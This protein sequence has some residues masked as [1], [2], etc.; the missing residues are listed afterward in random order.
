MALPRPVGRQSDV[1]Y[2]PSSGHQVILGTAGTGKTVMAM[3]RALHLASPD[4][5]GAG[6]VLLVTY[7]NALVTYLS[8]LRGG[9]AGGVTVETYGKFARGYLHSLGLMPGWGGI[10]GP[11]LRRTLVRKAVN[12]VSSGYKPSPFFERD[13]AFFLDELE[14]LSANGVTTLEE[15]KGLD[16]YGRKVG[17]S[18]A[19]RAAVWEIHEK[20]VGLRD[21]QGPRYDWYDLATSV[22]TA[23]GRDVRPRRYQHVVIDEGQDLSPE[24]IRSLVSAA[25]QSGSVTFF[26][27]YAQQIYGQDVSWRACGLNVR[28]VERFQDNYRNTA[29]IARLA[30][31]MSQ[32]PTFGGNPDDLVEPRAPRAAGTLPALVRCD[33]CDDEINIV[34]R[35][36]EELGR[37]GTVAVLGRTWA[38]A[39]R[40]SRGLTARKLHP[41]MATWD[42]SPGIYCGAYHS[43]KGL[44]FD[45]VL[46]PFCAAGKVPHPGVVRA[47]GDDEAASREAKLLYVGVTRARTDLIFTYSGEVS[48]LLPTDD[49]L[50]DRIMP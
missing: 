5:P 38:D 23:L 34:H 42:G 19:Q 31:A 9:A 33:S 29:E 36:A 40:A 13:V 16:R 26:G 41:E 35:L 50:W 45:A 21:V 43:A 15:Y 4:T 11:D 32:M 47:F 10:A 22:K 2:Y 30:I 46:L 27:D 14:W 20:Y 49:G 39:R 18:P 17:L 37:N 25:D 8:H 48:P 1:V 12:Q 28:R 7:N 6:P 24:A 3:L 44:E